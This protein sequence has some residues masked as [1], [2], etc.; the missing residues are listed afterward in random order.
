MQLAVIKTG[1]KQYV[2]SR[3]QR[4]AVEKLPYNEGDEFD[5]NEVLALVYA[6]QVK[7]GSPYVSGA[8]VRGKVLSHALH[9]KVIVFKFKPKKRQKRKRGHRQA[10]TLVEILDI[11]DKDVKVSD[12]VQDTEKKPAAVLLPRKVALKRVTKKSSE[13]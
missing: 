2:I 4:I 5:F 7:V 12:N 8:K 13:K 11:K 6:G 10:Y 3:G 1:G 9:D